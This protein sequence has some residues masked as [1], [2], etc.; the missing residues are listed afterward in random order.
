MPIRSSGPSRIAK[1]EIRRARTKRSCVHSARE[2]TAAQK[3]CQ[4]APAVPGHVTASPFATWTRNTT[5]I[6]AATIRANRAVR[7]QNHARR[8]ASRSSSFSR[9]SSTPKRL[10]HG[11]SRRVPTSTSPRKAATAPTV[12]ASAQYHAQPTS[13]WSQRK[14]AG[15]VTIA[16]AV[17]ASVSIRHWARSSLAASSPRGPEA[18]PVSI[19]ICRG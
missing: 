11:I 6:T 9:R 5:L 3:P 17:A 16:A 12:P 19:V 4:R 10:G 8:R 1:F 7:P 2:P 18:R 15:L 14:T 13:R